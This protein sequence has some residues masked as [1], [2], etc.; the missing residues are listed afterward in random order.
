MHTL[1]SGESILSVL[2]PS[3]RLINMMCGGVGDVGAKMYRCVH[4]GCFG[5]PM[6][7]HYL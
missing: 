5:G 1:D 7:S 3:S 4:A 2:I 6:H